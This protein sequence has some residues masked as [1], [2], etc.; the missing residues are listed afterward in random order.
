MLRINLRRNYQ[1]INMELN[2][3]SQIT[4]FERIYL[5]DLL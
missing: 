4:K 2:K 3:Y 1:K 5:N